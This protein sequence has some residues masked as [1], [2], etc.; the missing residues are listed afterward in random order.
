MTQ[1]SSSSATSNPNFNINTRSSRAQ[2]RN[3][4]SGNDDG[5]GNG[6]GNGNDGANGNVDGIG[7]VIGNNQRQRTV[8]AP[9]DSSYVGSRIFT[10]TREISVNI[11]SSETAGTMN[12]TKKYL[13][14]QLLRIISP[15][16]NQKANIY[17]N[18]RRNGTINQEVTFS[19]LFLCRIHPDEGMITDHSRL[20]YL[21]Q[22][23]NS[24]SYLFDDNKEWRD[25]GT[26]SIGT[27]FRILAPLPI[28]NNMNGDIPLVK[29]QLPIIIMKSP[30]VIPHTAINNAIQGNN[31]LAFVYNSVDL[32]V[33][34]TT[35]LH[36]TCGGYMC[37]RQRV[38]DWNGVRGCGCFDMS[39]FCSNLAFEHSLNFATDGGLI[40]HS[41]FS[42]TKFSLLYLNHHLPGSIK[43]SAIRMSSKNNVFFDIEDAMENVVDHVND[44][45]GW[46]IIGWY[47]RGIITD[48]SLIASGVTTNANNENEEIE[49]GQLTHHIV[50]IIPTDRSFLNETSINGRA[51]LRLKYD[52]SN[53][54]QV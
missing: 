17:S 35:P 31:A 39:N 33:I 14:V 50:Q 26:F 10:R 22:A 19:R 34:R 24:N 32:K 9:L 29:T 30:S 40:S 23:R 54:P 49:A 42:S 18:R 37:D 46:T 38:S 16:Q 47:K 15:S 25:N 45:G 27:F 36:T 3:G 12:L 48:K 11:L 1:S 44:N 13:L 7:N 8:L 4:G 52:V 20:I 41:N 2:N 5:E 21:M 6:N 28:E 43:V 53:L 51:L